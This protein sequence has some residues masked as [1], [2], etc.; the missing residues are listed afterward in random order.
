MAKEKRKWTKREEIC[1][2]PRPFLS[3]SLSPSFSL[4]LAPS[5]VSFVFCYHARGQ[6]SQVTCCPPNNSW[7]LLFATI[8]FFRTFFSHPPT[9]TF[10]KPTLL[11]YTLLFFSFSLA[12]QLTPY[13]FPNIFF[14]LTALHWPLTRQELVYFFISK[15]IN[16]QFTTKRWWIVKKN[17]LSSRY[18]K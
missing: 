16:T 4:T 17:V 2:G 15:S 14:P 9:S 10:L 8:T 5:S 18:S 1:T 11:N 13:L 6:E 3:L 7:P 12:L